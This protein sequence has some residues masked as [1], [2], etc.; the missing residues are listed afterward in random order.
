[1]DDPLSKDS[2]GGP[3]PSNSEKDPVAKS[4]KDEDPASRN[5]DNSE[6]NKKVKVRQTMRPVHIDLISWTSSQFICFFLAYLILIVIL[7]VL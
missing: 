6:A 1:M 4:N 5:I 2:A 3:V 7:K